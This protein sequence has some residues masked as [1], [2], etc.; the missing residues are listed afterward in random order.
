MTRSA[1]KK[2]REK[3]LEIRKHWLEWA[4]CDFEG[5]GGE[6]G[7]HLNKDLHSCNFGNASWSP[8]ITSPVPGSSKHFWRARTRCSLLPVS[9]QALLASLTSS[10]VLTPHAHHLV[11]QLQTMVATEQEERALFCTERKIYICRV[12]FSR[13]WGSNAGHEAY[14]HYCWASFQNIM[15]KLNPKSNSVISDY[16]FW[17]E[18]VIFGM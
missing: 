6:E 1:L 8:V 5:R 10:N 2:K 14:K 16:C 4:Y 3:R 15:W 12:F 9:L 7:A 13:H 18:M 17:D 11:W